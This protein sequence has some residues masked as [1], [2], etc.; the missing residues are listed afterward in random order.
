VPATLR[1]SGF[2]L[3][4]REKARSGT[5][6]GVPVDS[7]LPVWRILPQEYRPRIAETILLSI[8]QLT[9]ETQRNSSQVVV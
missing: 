1:V 9:S 6:L 2:W 7:T 4:F 3:D 8:G 5:V